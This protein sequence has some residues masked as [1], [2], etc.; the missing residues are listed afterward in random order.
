MGVCDLGHRVRAHAERWVAH[1]GNLVV[2]G[3]RRVRDGRGVP[4]H[5]LHP[6]AGGADGGAKSSG[7][8]YDEWYVFWERVRDDGDTDGDVGGRRGTGDDGDGLLRV[9]VAVGLESVERGWEA[10]ASGRR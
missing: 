6:R 1:E 8:F 5:A 2:P 4:V 9:R 3:G 10:H 7:E